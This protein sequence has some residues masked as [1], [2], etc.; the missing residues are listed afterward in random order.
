MSIESRDAATIV[1]SAVVQEPEFEYASD[2]DWE[3]E[4]PQNVV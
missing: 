4:G 3:G 1:P 2:A